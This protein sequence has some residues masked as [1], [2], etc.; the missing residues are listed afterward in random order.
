MYE[1]A[2]YLCPVRH[3]KAAFLWPFLPKRFHTG[4][5]A[6]GGQ[7]RQHSSACALTAAARLG[8]DAAMLHAVLRMLL[9]FIAA[10]AA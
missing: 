4:S 1:A 9:T 8:A 10:Q 6:S 5:P 7:R 2:L 3:T